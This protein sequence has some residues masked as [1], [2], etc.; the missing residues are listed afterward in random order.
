MVLLIITLSSEPHARHIT[1]STNTCG[2]TKWIGLGYAERGNY[3]EETMLSKC[4]KVG[5]SGCTKNSKHLHLLE[6]V[7]D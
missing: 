1:T 2:L 3:R 4:K 6:N 5:S 7:V